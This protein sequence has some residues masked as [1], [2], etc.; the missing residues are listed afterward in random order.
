M[1]F[2]DAWDKTIQWHKVNWLP[3]YLDRKAKGKG[4]TIANIGDKKKKV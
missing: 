2:E 3:G 1:S 4:S